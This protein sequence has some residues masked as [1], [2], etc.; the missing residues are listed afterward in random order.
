MRINKN[1]KDKLFRAVFGYEKYKENLLS[2][3]NALNGTDYEEP[4]DL[5]ITTIDDVVYM[6]MKNDI[7]CILDS[8][9]SLFEH[10]SSFNPNMRLEDLC[11]LGNCI[12]NISRR[13]ISTYT[14]EV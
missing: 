9:M 13:Q 12:R 1:N 7:S 4:D 3:F 8:S 10:Q 14:V 6:E 11:I 5:K 2:L